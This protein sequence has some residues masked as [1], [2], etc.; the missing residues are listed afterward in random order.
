MS[1]TAS[2]RL[3]S[4]AERLRI[5]EVISREPRNVRDIA[6]EIG[7]QPTAI[8]FHLRILEQL[9][10][11]ETKVQRGRVGRPTTLYRFTG[12]RVEFDFPRRKYFVLAEA[13]VTG[14]QRHLGEDKAKRVLR[15]IG[16]DV[17]SLIAS[18]LTERRGVKNWTPKHF[19][20]FFVEGLLGEYGT[21]PEVVK[22]TAKRVVYR[23]YNC[24]FQ[25]LAVKYP[26]LVCDV[27]DEA[28]HDGLRRQMS[29]SMKSSR[30]RCMGHGDP[31]CE[32][33]VRWPG[34][35]QL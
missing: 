14:I 31:Y 27:L 10:L 9:G 30:L 32:Y 2:S 24:I 33:A 7:L 25:D 35:R 16:L 8:R 13:L 11:V 12:K 29:P 28:F 22:V 4:S 26:K 21:Q 15:A 20:N 19:A 3:F 34:R 6:K 23:E 1:E 5:L 18:D 17:G